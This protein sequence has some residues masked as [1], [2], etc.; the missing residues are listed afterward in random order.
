MDNGRLPGRPPEHSTHEISDAAVAGSSS[1]HY[2]PGT[3]TVLANL[4]QPCC[5][6]VLSPT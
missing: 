4:G 2:Q 3:S 5:L 6:E 1:G